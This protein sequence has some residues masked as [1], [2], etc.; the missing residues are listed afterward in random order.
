MTQV[1]LQLSTSAEFW[2]IVSRGHPVRFEEFARALS[3]LALLRELEAAGGADMRRWHVC[4]GEVPVKRTGRS[5]TE[6]AKLSC[7][8]L[9]H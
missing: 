1:L 3:V 8:C 7:N 9:V 5:L 4:V 2:S 6:V